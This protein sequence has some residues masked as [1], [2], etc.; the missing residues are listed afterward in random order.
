MA[1]QLPLP[2]ALGMPQLPLVS[3]GTGKGS[4]RRIPSGRSSIQC[5]SQLQQV[6]LWHSLPLVPLQPRS[7]LQARQ[8]RLQAR[9]AW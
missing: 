2:L 3:S 7:W 5:Q 6:P 8:A 4:K 1:A 9:Q